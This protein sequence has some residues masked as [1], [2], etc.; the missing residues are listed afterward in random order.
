M[1]YFEFKIPKHTNKDIFIKISLPRFVFVFLFFILFAIITSIYSNIL[2][3]N[4]MYSLFTIAI[5]TILIISYYL[6]TESRDSMK[7]SIQFDLDKDLLIINETKLNI[8][9]V[10]SLNIY[11]DGYRG[12]S[13]TNKRYNYG[14]GNILKIKIGNNNIITQHFFLDEKD[15]YLLQKMLDKLY[16]MKLNI[17]ETSSFGKTI[18]GIPYAS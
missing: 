17:I 15:F 16:L 7:H 8:K 6:L 11:I 5:I 10:K 12:Q 1:N 9:D 3:N 4:Y 18:A 13:G 2:N 14:I